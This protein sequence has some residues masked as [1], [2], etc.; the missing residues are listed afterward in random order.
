MDKNNGPRSAAS[1]V[2]WQNTSF[3]S[4]IRGF[5]SPRSLHRQWVLPP[6]TGYIHGGGIPPNTC[7]KR[8]SRDTLWRETP[9]ARSTLIALLTLS[10]AGCQTTAK[11]TQVSLVEPSA[12]IARPVGGVYYTIKKGD[13]LMDISRRYGVDVKEIA[14]ANGIRDTGSIKRGH[15]ILIPSTSPTRVALKKPESTPVANDPFVWPV[16][17]TV[18][19]SFG[20]K[21]GKV[22]NKGID[23][24]ADEGRSVVASRAGRVVFCDDAFK[25][26]GKTVILDHGDNFQTVY[27]YNAIILVGLGDLVRQRDEIARVGSTGRAKEPTLHFEIRKSGEPQNPFSYLSK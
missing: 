9:F 4:S 2:Q 6:E 12:S 7:Q 16:R 5:D 17:G 10:L 27:A 25:G 20:S 26:F 3:P 11:H 8:I 23:I 18:V 21:S 22:R 15:A 19:S 1:V 13:T 24:R 14:Q